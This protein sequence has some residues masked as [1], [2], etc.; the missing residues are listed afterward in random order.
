MSIVNVTNVVV[1]DN[2]TAFKNPLTFEVTFECLEA[3]DA[4]KTTAE[5]FAPISAMF[6]SNFERRCW[7]LE[8]AGGGAFAVGA[9]PT[10]GSTRS[11]TGA[12]AVR[13][14]LSRVPIS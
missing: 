13:M 7:R 10:L 11:V 9:S 2:P 6:F 8:A 12:M 3:L 5:G 14:A 1:L 4:G